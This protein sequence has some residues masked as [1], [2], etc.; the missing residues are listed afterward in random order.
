[1]DQR[2]PMDREY[3]VKNLLVERYL[4]G[5]LS[6]EEQT[7][8]EEALLSSEDLLDQLE[9]AELLQQGM[10]DVATL[11]QPQP[12]SSRP[13]WFV[14]MFNSPRYAMAASFLLLVSLGVSSTL[15]HQLG[16]RDGPEFSI[17]S[18]QIVPLVSVRGAPGDRSVN[19]VRIGERNE[20][21]VLMLDPG[22]DQ[23]AR[24][25]ATVYR[26]QAGAEPT[27]VIQVD[28]LRPGYEEMLALALSSRVL[29]P[30]DYQ[31]TIEGWRDEWPADHA[32]ERIDMVPLRVVSPSQ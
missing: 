8:F 32:F 14:S 13:S 26:L 17:T 9:S 7:A 31:V 5:S 24:Y 23:Y 2:E 20:Q 27:Q 12:A 18:T 21:T 29:E 16:Q 30:G 25:R 19:T 6:A 3:I 10:N 11:E 4:Q 15:L 22:F 1:M 28:D